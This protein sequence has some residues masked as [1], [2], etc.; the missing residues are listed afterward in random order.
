MHFVT[1][2]T[3]FAQ[4]IKILPHFHNSAHRLRTHRPVAI[5]PLP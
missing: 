3:D 5:S 1:Q 2:N 4:F